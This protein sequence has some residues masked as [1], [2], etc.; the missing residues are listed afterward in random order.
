MVAVTL[1]RL[2]VDGMP[3]AAFAITLG[4]ALGRVA[5]EEVNGLAVIGPLHGAIGA[6]HKLPV[7]GHLVGGGADIGG[8]VHRAI[9]ITSGLVALVL[10]E[11]IKRHA[12]LRGEHGGLGANG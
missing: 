9:V 8:P 2:F 10:V 4:I 7:V 1:P 6:L 11:G 5:L 12:V 3:D